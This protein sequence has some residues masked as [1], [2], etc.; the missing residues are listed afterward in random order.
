M[1]E[2]P[3]TPDRVMIARSL[4]GFC[5]SEPVHAVEAI[6]SIRD[7]HRRPDETQLSNNDEGRSVAVGSPFDAARFLP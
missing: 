1:Y 6:H 4:D 5:S 7:N 3:R 2:T